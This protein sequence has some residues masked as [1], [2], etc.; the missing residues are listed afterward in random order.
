MKKT[1]SF[2]K[3]DYNNKG[4]RN[5]KVTIEVELKDG[6][7]SICGNVWNP[8]ET[9]IY[10]GGQNLD[11]I[12]KLLRGN[13]KVKRIHEIWQRWHLNHMRAGSPRQRAYLE[14]Q[15]FPGYP[16]SHYTWACEVLAAAGLQPDNEYI[17]NGKPY[18]Y[19]SA[20][21]HEELPAEI[22]AEVESW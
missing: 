6:E 16:L 18:S 19:G 12:R 5:C 9:D 21:L 8:S 2:G 14:T 4:R 1:L 15:T 17:H 13:P 11:E 10:S 7:L 3:V 20:W 22:I